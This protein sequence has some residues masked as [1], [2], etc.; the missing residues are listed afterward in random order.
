M[1]SQYGLA[2][3]CCAVA[4][5][6][7]RIQNPLAGIPRETL[8]RNV[9]DFAREVDLVDMIPLLRKGA[10]VAQ[11]PPVFE[12][13]E[14]L[15]N[16]EREAL[17]NEVLH[18]WRQPRSLYITVILCSVGAA[19]QG[20]DQTGSN[21]ANLSFPLAFGIGNGDIPG[22]PNQER[23]NWLVGLI[24]AAPYIASAFFGC[25]MSDP[26]NNYVGRRGT[27]FVAA[28]FCL[29][30]V[31]GSGFSQ[32]WQQLFVTRLLLGV[33]MG[34]KAST[35]PIYA[36]ENCPAAIRGGLVMS[37][38]MWTAFG[39]FLGFCANLAVYN[40]GAIAWRLQLG[41][42]FIPAVPL[43]VGIY[44]CPGK[45]LTS[46]AQ[47]TLTNRL[48]QNR[49]VGISR[50]AA[51]LKLTSLSVVYEIRLFRPP[52]ISTIFMPKSWRKQRSSDRVLISLDSLNSSPS[53]VSVAPHSLHGQS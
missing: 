33:G 16:N 14:E 25:W 2:L 3:L 4:E 24:N 13:I 42:A 53:P 44:F 5:L 50:R 17:R 31:I 45:S 11:D 7:H 52:G 46:V 8:F 34:C 32:T 30:S 43:V 9:E 49:R 27:I 19:V 38:Q 51:I 35:V 15:D 48:R 36:A 1:P 39:I 12:S 18:K 20:W 22:A 29:F 28:I 40:V 26:L 6:L 47:S 41:S 10:L 37:W 21:G 23:D